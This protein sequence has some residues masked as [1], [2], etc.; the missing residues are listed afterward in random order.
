MVL[1]HFESPDIYLLTNYP[2]SLLETQN[3]LNMKI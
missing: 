1:V 2:F 3:Y